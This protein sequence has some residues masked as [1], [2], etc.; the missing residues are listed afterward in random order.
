MGFKNGSFPY[1]DRRA[2][3]EE[4]ILAGNFGGYAEAVRD[5]KSVF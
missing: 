3:E 1:I 4:M 2:K 5:V